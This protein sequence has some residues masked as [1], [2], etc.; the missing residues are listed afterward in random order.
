MGTDGFLLVF[1]ISAK[2]TFQALEPI[3]LKIMNYFKDD[4]LP[5]VVVGTKCDQE[6][7]RQV[8]TQVAK[9]WASKHGFGYIETSART[10]HNISQTFE[11]LIDKIEQNKEKGILVLQNPHKWK[12]TS[13]TTPVTCKRCNTLIWGIAFKYGYTCEGLNRTQIST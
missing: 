4:R 2:F 11:L 9:D 12:K 7:Q 10:G 5:I 8:P 3:R 1:S 13:F 6:S